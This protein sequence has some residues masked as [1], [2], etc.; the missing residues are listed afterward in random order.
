MLSLGKSVLLLAAFWAVAVRAAADILIIE[1]VQNG[2]ATDSFEYLQAI[3]LGLSVDIK[4]LDEFQTLTTAEFSEYKALVINPYGRGGGGDG[5][6]VDFLVNSKARWGPAVTG[7][8]VIPG[9]DPGN[10]AAYTPG[11]LSVIRSGISF[12]SAGS[13]TGFYLQ[14]PKSL[15]SGSSGPTDFGFLDVFGPGMGFTVDYGYDNVHLVATHPALLGL[16]DADLSNWGASVHGLWTSYPQGFQPLS[17]VIGTAGPGAQ[18]FEDGTS[19]V[20]YIIARGALPASC[21]N[22]VVNGGEE[23]DDGTNQNGSDGS[24]CSGTCTCLYGFTTDESNAKVCKAAPRC[25]DGTVNSG[26]Q[27]DAGDDGDNPNGSAGTL[28]AA[29]CTCKYGTT[30]DS[31]GNTGCSAASCGDGFINQDSEE[32]DDGS[33]NGDEGL[34]SSACQ[35]NYGTRGGF[36]AP[37]PVCGDGFVNGNDECDDG[38]LNGSEGSVCS[39]SCQCVYGLASGDPEDKT[40]NGPPSCGDGRVNEASEQC[41]DGEDNGTDSSLCDV[42]CTC[43]FGLADDGA[44]CGAEPVCGDGVVGFREECDD[45]EDNS[46]ERD[47]LCGTS[48]LCNYGLAED[49]DKAEGVCK[50]PPEIP[51]P[52]PQNTDTTGTIDPTNTTPDYPTPPAPEPESPYNPPVVPVDEPEYPDGVVGIEY[53][54]YIEDEGN[55]DKQVRRRHNKGEPEKDP[56][57]TRAIYT[58]QIYATSTGGEP[59]YPKVIGTP[60]A[61][62]LET[63]VTT[64]R[65][66]RKPDPTPVFAFRL[67][68]DCELTTTTAPVPGYTPGVCVGCTLVDELPARSCTESISL[69]KPGK[70]TKYTKGSYPIATD[71]TH[72]IAPTAVI[73]Y[74]EGIVT[75]VM[76]TTTITLTTTCAGHGHSCMPVTTCKEYPTMLTVPWEYCTTSVSTREDGSRT[77]CTEVPAL[78]ALPTPLL[79]EIGYNSEDLEH[80]S[81]YSGPVPGSDH[82]GGEAGGKGKDGSLLY[83]DLVPS[84]GSGS[85]SGEYVVRRHG[86][87]LDQRHPV[88]ATGAGAAVSESLTGMILFSIVVAMLY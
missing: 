4:S 46:D 69:S 8:V 47:A 13:S 86:A 74:P 10:H 59:W 71:D 21:G 34:C 27:C 6:F 1:P 67:C 63:V 84:L 23:C 62:A 58:R 50:N 54:Y 65:L 57:Y 41:D 48:C 43:K 22:G 31:D 75:K 49:E 37:K 79:E 40:C 18:T 9:A 33:A 7:N 2:P 3:D 72:N 77:T 36:C 15:D 25:G 45:G 19:G 44:S 83:G 20:P 76:V 11:A 52:E 12:A 26:E 29:D 68:S 56:E 51:D 53:I 64:S 17:I 80:A 70:A 39:E 35:C 81:E 82:P 14:P 85:G 88:Q 5:P 87:G 16:S 60:A 28:C 78:W 24:L 30:T 42:S 73:T 61:D 66:C 38:D 32:C 55:H